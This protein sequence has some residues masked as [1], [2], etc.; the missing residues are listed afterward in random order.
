MG[1]NTGYAI[2]L[3]LGSLLTGAL[4]GLGPLITGN[5]KQQKSLGI[6]GFFACLVSG[7][8][9]GIILA[10]PVCIIFIV[11]IMVKS[12]KSINTKKCPYCAE[13]IL[14]EAIVCKHCKNDVI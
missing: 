12:K 14:A 3:I 7:F 6:A 1:Y 8:I 9:L 2:G 10:L 13:E 5:I 4:F 11:L